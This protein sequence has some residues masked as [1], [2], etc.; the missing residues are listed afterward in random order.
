MTDPSPE[1]PAPEPGPDGPLPAATVRKRR[2]R[3]PVVWVVPLIAAIVAATLVYNRLQEFGPTITIKFRDG[4]GV[5]AGQTE[6]RYRGVPVGQVT[7]IELTPD[8][9]HVVVTARLERIVRDQTPAPLPPSPAA[10][11]ADRWFE[12]V[13]TNPGAPVVEDLTPTS[14]RA[15]PLAPHRSLSPV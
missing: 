7:T 6:I 13:P 15:A 10:A 2:W 5:K 12:Q 8:H 11:D 14:H 4:S 9:E 3:F 1:Q